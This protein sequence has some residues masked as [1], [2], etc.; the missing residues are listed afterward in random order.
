[1][2]VIPRYAVLIGAL[3]AALTGCGAGTTSQPPGAAQPKADL[4]VTI[5]AHARSTPV[6]WTLR[7]DPAGGTVPDPAAAC[8]ALRRIRPFAQRSIRMACPMIMAGDGRIV[9]TGTWYG[10]SVHRNFIDGGC[11]LGHFRELHKIFG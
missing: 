1:M 10:Q 9:V 4:T 11:D 8:A 5:R 6:R 7:C 3:A 2:S